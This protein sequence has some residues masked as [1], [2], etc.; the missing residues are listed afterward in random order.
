MSRKYSIPF[1][2]KIV[3]TDE[4]IK[5]IVLVA[6][7]LSHE[8]LTIWTPCMN[9]LEYIIYLLIYTHII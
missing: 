6:N 2:I 8:D 1:N 9:D 3:T 4:H 7:F 5:E